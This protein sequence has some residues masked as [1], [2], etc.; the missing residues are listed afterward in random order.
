MVFIKRSIAKLEL[1]GED[2]PGWLK[3]SEA[4]ESKAD[5][6]KTEAKLDEQDE[7]ESE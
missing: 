3:K 1:S 7:E 5:A 2:E 4:A 6:K